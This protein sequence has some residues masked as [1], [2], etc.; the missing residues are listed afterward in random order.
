LLIQK[1]E[2]RMRNKLGLTLRILSVAG[3]VGTIVAAQSAN[4]GNLIGGYYEE[5]NVDFHN[6]GS[7]LDWDIACAGEEVNEL[8]HPG[9]YKEECWGEGCSLEERVE[10]SEGRNVRDRS[11]DLMLNHFCVVRGSPNG[12]AHGWTFVNGVAQE[13]F[14]SPEVGNLLC[15]D[16]GM[17]GCQFW[18]QSFGM[19]LPMC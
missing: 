9:S 13:H 7:L 16:F 19:I 4:A 6:S 5:C 3:V 10:L 8:Y 2:I 12:S 11:H 17:A 14:R 18:N 1:G 15:W